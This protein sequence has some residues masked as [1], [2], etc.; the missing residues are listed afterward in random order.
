MAPEGKL[1]FFFAFLEGLVSELEWY[2]D[3][4]N[5]VDNAV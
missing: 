1:F 3:G 4:E 5:E 2:G